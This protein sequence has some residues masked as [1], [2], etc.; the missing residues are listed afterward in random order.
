[1]PNHCLVV[2]HDRV[3]VIF[4]SRDEFSLLVEC[5]NGW[6]KISNVDKV[7][8]AIPGKSDRAR[9]YQQALQA[10]KASNCRWIY[11]LGFQSWWQNEMAELL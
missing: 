4:E 3:N 10:W 7:M 8:C 5:E 9:L 11:P 2:Y 1:M 6:L